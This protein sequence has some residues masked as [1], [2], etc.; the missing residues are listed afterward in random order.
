MPGFSLKTIL[1]LQKKAFILELFLLVIIFASASFKKDSEQTDYQLNYNSKLND[2]HTKQSTLAT[3]IEN[4][5]LSS[6]EDIE[7]IK[8]QIN[9]VRI[10]L[11]ALDFWFRYLELVSYK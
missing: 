4:S 5:D 2:F 11:K 8:E 3:R 7:K 6:D 9:L 1:I 10:S